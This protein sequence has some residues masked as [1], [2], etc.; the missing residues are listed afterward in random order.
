MQGD[1]ENLNYR[2]TAVEGIRKVV[3]SVSNGQKE[4]SS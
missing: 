4:F 1:T 2:L 3:F